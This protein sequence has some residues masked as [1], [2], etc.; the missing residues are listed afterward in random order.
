MAI[1]VVCLSPVTLFCLLHPLTLAHT[2]SEGNSW[3]L[4]P[5]SLKAAD[6]VALKVPLSGHG[7]QNI[8]EE[9]PRNISMIFVLSPTCFQI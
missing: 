1:V 6:G 8:Q 3:C 2:L 5:F 7:D 4:N 9:A